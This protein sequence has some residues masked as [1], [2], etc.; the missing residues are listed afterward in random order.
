MKR[1]NKGL[2][3]FG[4]TYDRVRLKLVKAFTE[5]ITKHSDC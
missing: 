3:M 5:T 2:K 4:S 1:R